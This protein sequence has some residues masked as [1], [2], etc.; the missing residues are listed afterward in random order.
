MFMSDFIRDG[1][2]GGCSAGL[3]PTNLGFRLVRGRASA[4]ARVIS[5][6]SA[7]FAAL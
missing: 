3:P 6:V 4:V 2:T 1:V 7:L 5:G